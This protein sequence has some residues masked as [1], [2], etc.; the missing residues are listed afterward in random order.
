MEYK[1]QHMEYVERKTQN[2]ECECEHEPMRTD[3]V[4]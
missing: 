4:D 1:N 2:M 3:P